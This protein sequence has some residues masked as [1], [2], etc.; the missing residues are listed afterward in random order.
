MSEITCTFKLKRGA[1]F[2]TPRHLGLG[3]DF[4]NVSSFSLSKDEIDFLS[5]GFGFI[6]TPNDPNYRDELIKD[7]H[8]FTRKLA[9]TDFFSRKKRNTS[10][11]KSKCT[12]KS[13]WEPSI[14]FIK[15]TTRD[16]IDDIDQI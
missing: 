1:H 7:A 15:E 13:S 12:H 8:N 9:I 4:V 2:R 16:I 6:E 10:R 14:K 3:S 11:T 5:L